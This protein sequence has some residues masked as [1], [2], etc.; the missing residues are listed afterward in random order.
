M[1]SAPYSL[2]RMR[3]QAALLLSAAAVLFALN[4]L[5]HPLFHSH[6]ECGEDIH[7]GE[8]CLVCSGAFQEAEPPHI[9]ELPHQE[10]RE[11]FPLLN[12]SPAADPLPVVPCSRG[13]PVR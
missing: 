12:T 6:K 4:V 11:R 7:A 8:F 1:R 3:R 9:Q 2:F 5:L 10:H 13:P